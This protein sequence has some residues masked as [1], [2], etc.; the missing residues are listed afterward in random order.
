MH[1][2]K[3][4]AV[5]DLEARA[6]VLPRFPHYG[7]CLLE[8]RH[9]D[10]FT[11]PPS[12]YDF[13]EVMLVIGGEGWVSHGGIRHPLK[14]GDLIAV[15]AGDA[16]FLT[17]SEEAPLAVFC[18]CIRPTHQ[19]ELFAPL[20]PK[21]FAV[22]RNLPL[23]Q[24]A[25]LHLRAILLEQT[26]PGE[27]SEAVVTAQTLLLLSKLVRK[28]GEHRGGYVAKLRPREVELIARVRD[29]AEALEKRFHESETIEAVAER[30]GMSSRSLTTYFRQVTGVSRQRY[31]QRLRID[32]ACQLLESPGQS[33]TSIAFACGFEDLST[34]FRAFR[35][36]KKMSPAQWREREPNGPPLPITPPSVS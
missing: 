13:W 25:T 11:M 18:L 26:C 23:S 29:Y 19:K 10:T 27:C 15:P 20:L 35:L 31:I 36:M 30:L 2:T 3:I 7:L 5:I 24:Q 21:T 9:A 17:D 1:S 22:I 6:P 32:Y 33:I 4:Q 8:S 34:F 28:R 16:Y 14:G 12:Q